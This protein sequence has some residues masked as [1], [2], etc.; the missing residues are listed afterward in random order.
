[1]KAVAVITAGQAAWLITKT[2]VGQS[3]AVMVETTPEQV[4]AIKRRRITEIPTLHP[5]DRM[6]HMLEAHGIAQAMHRHRI[7]AADQSMAV[8]A[9]VDI[10]AAASIGRSR[11]K[12]PSVSPQG[13]EAKRLRRFAIGQITAASA[14][15]RFLLY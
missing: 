9:A 3:A 14:P 13:G 6:R 15:L 11:L 2:V 4:A 1:M 12:Q 5:R 8:V 10:K 7:A